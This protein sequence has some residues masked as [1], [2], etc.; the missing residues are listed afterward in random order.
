MS[1]SY[2]V[3]ILGGGVVG[4]TLALALAR[5]NRRVA[6]VTASA[7]GSP[8]GQSPS[9]DVRAYALNAASRQWLQSLQ[10]WPD[11]AA[12]TP[13]QHMHVW[14]DDGG[15][16]IFSAQPEQPL[17][18]IVDVPA[19][20]HVLHEQVRLTAGITR[21]DQPVAASLW[22]VCEGRHSATR[23]RLGAQRRRLPYGQTALATRVR[24]SHPHC[25]QA[26]QWFQSSETG[27]SI[28]ALLPM[29]GANAHELAVVWSLPHDQA[30]ALSTCATSDF[31]AQIQAHSRHLMGPLHVTA[32]RLT[33]PLEWGQAD[34]W[35]GQDPTGQA[36]VLAGDAARNIH[37]LAGLGLNLGLGDARVL[38]D[39]LPTLRSPEHW[40]GL[41]DLRVLRRYERQRKAECAVT[42]SVID[43]L[44]RLFAHPHP[45]AQ[46]WRNAG[47]TGLN[48]MPSLK[49]W[50]IGQALSPL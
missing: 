19:L 6:W 43:G 47:L 5:Q 3:C 10:A 7:Q 18:W 36:W 37:P 13:V 35:C 8:T 33:W 21:V 39:T 17:T 27:P 12:C 20:E 49:Q 22:V 34:T 29:G 23:T 2:D 9:T 11:E 31:E 41:D 4:H 38:M 24:A 40:R 50:I 32:D 44:Q 25:N 1:I 30:Q 42:T 15:D 46:H 14:G 26:S 48:Q 45:W 16:V 28:L